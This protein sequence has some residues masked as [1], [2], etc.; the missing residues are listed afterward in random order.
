ML[1][2][3]AIAGA[4]AA[5]IIGGGTAALAAS[6]SSGAPGTPSTS[7]S[8][9]SSSSSADKKAGTGR[10]ARRHPAVAALL[11]HHAAHGQI[12]TDDNGKYVIHDG[13]VGTVS[14][15]SATSIAVKSGDGFVQT[16]TVNSS[17]KVRVGTDGKDSAIADV[18]PGAKVGV[19]GTAATATS[20]PVATYIVA[21]A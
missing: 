18:H 7:S 1:R 14:A 19:V 12:V 16:Y 5:V 21:E 6:G 17:T 15:V 20:A 3:V 2:K 4:T 8:S 9:S 13:I 10:F 11:R